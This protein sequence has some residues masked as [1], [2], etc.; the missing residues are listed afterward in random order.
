[1]VT[2]EMK[3][4]EKQALPGGGY[5]YDGTGVEAGM[6]VGVGVSVGVGVGIRVTV[7][8]GVFVGSAVNVAA[9]AVLTSGPSSLIEAALALVLQEARTKVPIES[10]GKRNFAGLCFIGITFFR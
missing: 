4:A 6:A 1:M 3:E 10:I 8:A 9:T 7:G 5:V 2:S